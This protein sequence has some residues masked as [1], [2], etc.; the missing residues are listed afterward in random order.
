MGDN[1]NAEVPDHYG[2][3]VG[4]NSYDGYL[5][6]MGIVGLWDGRARIKRGGDPYLGRPD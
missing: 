3:P 4:S 6:G 2:K 5:T 1:D